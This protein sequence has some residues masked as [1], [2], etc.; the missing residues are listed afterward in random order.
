M[1][2]RL[3]DSHGEFEVFEVSQTHAYDYGSVEH[4]FDAPVKREK[5]DHRN[6]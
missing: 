3:L 2:R 6:K 1:Q 5:S 4:L